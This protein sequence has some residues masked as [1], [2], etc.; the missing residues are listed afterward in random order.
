MLVP[1]I[2]AT[3]H[4]QFPF[5][6]GRARAAKKN[7]GGSHH[8]VLLHREKADP[9]GLRQAPDRAGRALPAGDPDGLLPRVPAG[10]RPDRQ[11]RGARPAC[12]PEIGVPDLQLL[13]QRRAGIRQLQARRAAVRRARV[14]QP[15]PD[16]RRPA[17]RDRAP[18]DLR[19][20]VVDQGDQ[21]REGAGGLH[22]R[23]APDDRQR[24]LHR[25]R[26]RARHRLAAAPF[27]GR[28]LR[29][30]PRQDPQLGQAAVQRPHHSLPR[31]LA[32]LRVRPEGR[33]CSPAST[34]AASCR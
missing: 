19:P 13:R 4:W 1:A 21:V 20:R 32:R 11:A 17:A 5:P 6:T 30:R 25:Q 28:V 18:G 2:P 9:Q 16:L 33:A 34:A 23:A 26:H 31:L 10:V 3:S 14:P 12:G 8:D 15:R 27:A 29:P 22:G 24:H 7:R